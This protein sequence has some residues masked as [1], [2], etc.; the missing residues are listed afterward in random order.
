[1]GGALPERLD[2]P[3]PGTVA[4]NEPP[5][6]PKANVLCLPT[7]IAR[8]APACSDTLPVTT[9]PPDPAPTTVKTYDP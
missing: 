5:D 9:A 1:M 2:S 7:R 3:P 6:P 8:V 4:I